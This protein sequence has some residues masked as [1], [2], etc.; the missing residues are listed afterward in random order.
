VIRLPVSAGFVALVAVL[1]VSCGGEGKARPDLAFVSTR[2]GP[3]AIY[4]M[5]ANGR[6]QHRLTEADTDVS[7][8]EG[9]FFQVEPAWSPDGAKIAFSSGRGGTLDIYVMNAD[10]TGTVQLTTKGD[11]E[12]HPT[13][14]ADG[15]EIAFAQAQDI[16]VMNADGSDARRISD[17]EVAESEPAWSPNGKSIAYV[18]RDPGTDVRDLWI[19]RPDGAG[20]RRVTSLHANSVN[21]AWSPDSTRLAFA[22]NVLGQLYDIFTV[23][24]GEKGVRR[25]SR[26]GPDAFE[27]SW[28][29]DGTKVAFSQNGSILTVDLERNTEEL[30]DP[31]GNDSSP[32]WNPK[33]PADE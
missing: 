32:A 13:W 31:D 15:G 20:A 16:Y 11:D 14:S 3:Y 2:D 12:S 9:L 1:L 30:T 7:K 23:T 10:G 8:P 18:R 19:M 24:V 25:L 21:P 26:V 28:S 29:P 5:N 6:A 17:P 4:E 33:P 22:S 27:P